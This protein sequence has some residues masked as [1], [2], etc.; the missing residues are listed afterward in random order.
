MNK[1]EVIWQHCSHGAAR[2]TEKQW[3]HPIRMHS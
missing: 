3:K 1:F 2:V